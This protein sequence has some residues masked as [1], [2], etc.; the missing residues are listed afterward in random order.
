[1][2]EVFKQKP[3]FDDYDQSKKFLSILG[4]A[5]FP[6][7]A[8]EFNQVQSILQNQIARL[9]D[10]FFKDG[11]KIIDGELAIDTDVYSV[12]LANYNAN[13]LAGL[14]G[15]TLTGSESQ[16]KGKVLATST[17]DKGNVLLIVKFVSSDKETNNSDWTTGEGFGSD[18]PSFYIDG[19]ND[20]IKPASVAQI[21]QGIYYIDQYFVLVEGQTL[22]LDSTSNT[23]SY[24]IGLQVTKSVVTPE[25]DE[26]LLDNAIGSYNYTAP[27][28]HRFKIECTLAKIPLSQSTDTDSF[29][30]LAQ[31]RGGEIVKQTTTTTYNELEKTLARR[32]Y[33]ESGDYTVRPFKLIVREH[34]S[35][36]RGTWKPK[37]KYL[38]GDIVRYGSTENNTATFTAETS[39]T[40][41]TTGYPNPNQQV[42]NDSTDDGT[43]LV[44]RKTID[45]E[46]NNGVY[47]AEGK[48]TSIEILDQGNKYVS[49]PTIEFDSSSGSGASAKAIISDGKLIRVDIVDGGSGYLLNDVTVKVIGG[50]EQ[51]GQICYD[52]GSDGSDQIPSDAIAKAYTDSGDDTKLAIGLESG[53]AYV[54]GFEIEKIGTTWIPIDKARTSASSKDVFLTPSV[55][56]YFKVTNVQ[57]VITDRSIDIYSKLPAKQ[58]NG[59]WK[60]DKSSRIGSCKVRGLEFEGGDQ[61]NNPSTATYKLFVYD[62]AI[63]QGY[64]LTTD[65]TSLA[66]TTNSSSDVAEFV[67][68]IKH[69]LTQLTGTVSK[70]ESSYNLTGTG[71]SFNTEVPANHYIVVNQSSGNKYYYINN[72]SGQNQAVVDDNTGSFDNLIFYQP[73]T[74]IYEASNGSLIY[75]LPN[76]VIKTTNQTNYEIDYSLMQRLVFNG[77]KGELD[78]NGKYAV[79]LT[80]PNTINGEFASVQGNNNYVVFI[81]DSSGSEIISTTFISGTSN[82][83]TFEPDQTKVNDAVTS[84]SFIVLATIRNNSTSGRATKTIVDKTLTNITNTQSTKS[85]S[86]GV[87]DAFK[88]IKVTG[89]YSTDENKVNTHD[90]TDKYQLIS[91]QT[92]Y[93]YGVSS[94]ALKSQYTVPPYDRL[95]V[96]FEYYNHSNGDYFTVDSYPNYESV[97]SYNGISLRDVIDFRPRIVDDTSSIKMIKRGTEIQISYDY[98]LGRK[99]KI[100]L[101]SD[102]NFGVVSGIP[103]IDPQL[104]ETPDMSMNLYELTIPPY[105]FDTKIDV[106]TIDNKRYTMRD[107]GKLE[108]RIN[109]LEQYTALSLL[110]Q[111]TESMQI[112]DQSGLTRFKQGFVV[113]NFRTPSLV[114]DSDS[115]AICSIDIENQLC[116]P[117]YINH[118]IGLYEYLPN[119]TSDSVDNAR[120][121]NNYKMYGKVFT[122]PLDPINPHIAIVEQRLASR[123]VNI[124][125]Y[126][127]ATFIGSLSINPSS[128]DWYD[129]KYLADNVTNVEGN[130]LAT[131]NALEG[132]IWNGWQT[133]WLGAKTTISS[134]SNTVKSNWGRHIQNGNIFQSSGYLTTITTTS[135]QQVGQTRTGIKT[136][137]TATTDYQQVGDRLVSTTL[138]PYLRSRW[139][140]VRAYR[141]KPYTKY[142]PFFDNVNVDYFTVPCSRI[143]VEYKGSNGKTFD[144]TTSAGN[145][146]GSVARKIVATANSF[147]GEQTDRTALDIG[148][149]ITQ[150]ASTG[151]QSSDVIPLTAVVVGASKEPSVLN[152][153][154]IVDVIYVTNIKNQS[155]PCAS[156][157]NGMNDINNLV[158]FT[159]GNTIT[160]SV[161]GVSAVVKYAQG[162]PNP[163]VDSLVTNSN[164]ELYLMFWIPDNS[165][166]DYNN[167]QDITPVFQFTCGDRVFALSDDTKVNNA[168]AEGVYSAVGILNTRQRDINAVRNAKV[169]R[170]NVSKSRVISQTTTDTSYK[171]QPVDPLAQTFSIP[172]EGGCFLSKVDIYFA[173]KPKANPLGNN[174][175]DLLPV[176]L[177]IRTCENGIPTQTILPFAEVTLRPDQVNVSSNTVEYLDD[178]NNVITAYDYSTPTT[179][180]FESPVFVDQTKEYAVVLLSDSNDYNVWVAHVGDTVPGDTSTISKQPYTGTLLKSQNASTWTPEQMEDL[181]FVVYRA[182]FNIGNSTTNSQLIGNIRLA[183]N[184]PP[185]DN[186][187]RNCFEMTANSKSVRVYHDFH[188]LKVGDNVTLS[189][190][191]TADSSINGIPVT[192]LVGTHKVTGVDVNSYTFDAA[193]ESSDNV[194][195]GYGGDDNWYSTPNYNYD[196]IEP[197]VT[198]QSFSDTQVSFSMTGNTASTDRIESTS[199]IAIDVNDNN[200]FTSPMVIRS[201]ANNTSTNS[202]DLII[203]VNMTSN[204]QALSPII[205]TDRL[206]AVLINNI[207]NK[208]LAS[209][210]QFIAETNPT[211]GSV[212]CKYITKPVTLNATSNMIKVMFAGIVPITSDVEVYYKSYLTG[213]SKQYND[214]PWV[215]I[216]NPEMMHSDDWID[217]EF[218]A[219]D[220]PGF[221]VIAIKVVFTGTN[222]SV[223]P[224]IK[225]FRL[226]ACV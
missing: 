15:V 99:D 124:N 129:T 55:G 222:S 202:K 195:G 221:D 57:G 67:C 224:M 34:R 45:P 89:Y 4:R 125:P 54:R 113:D 19:S 149:V 77:V 177:Q 74:I 29:I 64:N 25:Q 70:S 122:L 156:T 23:P 30:E 82:S 175:G 12:R 180:E 163:N 9:G 141:L 21:N 92:D 16:A 79:T 50:H 81:N 27:G 135:S 51:Q 53:K 184:V 110:E 128:D 209:D 173:S 44:W 83:I 78:S 168:N 108:Q 197:S 86:L 36:D 210:P 39:G 165:K 62:I 80:L 170:T 185:P 85:I 144:Y 155:T 172:V 226:I 73:T 72:V 215:K 46:F 11:S 136:T 157:S 40:S 225:D 160:G 171:F 49:E 200:N 123:T 223:V 153:S 22:I 158:T 60:V 207:I 109:T 111:Q 100:V 176:T 119:N 150:S 14:V 203:N 17:D 93:C 20:A 104:P 31:I 132:T 162:N 42:T 106:N 96:E 219:E 169:S 211:G 94:I 37:T 218:D 212:Y 69:S 65:A 115:D 138:I 164:G 28:A 95:D 117:S 139:L 35:N 152:S 220:V 174:T 142:Y 121:S 2:T 145:D 118:N 43:G 66:T 59:S 76:D 91:G 167:K 193:I 10:H 199:Q 13:A 126:A 127:V 194:V 137:V 187:E 88:L 97:P 208:P 52:I 166:I 179:F 206:S 107:I 41:S 101:D 6:L 188:G 120:A 182:N 196:I 63:D 217:Y 204:N 7:Q 105:T 90:I 201:T 112:T 114:N 148:D 5:S 38:A 151:T 214:V 98:Y 75:K 191:D 84:H 3:Y 56:N 205:D 130:Y 147:W 192:G 140:L 32:T 68:D 33:D 18:Y 58:S 190:E 24:R 87:A 189:N 198:Y 181:K 183:A 116:R 103:N 134:T 154:K 143:E 1:M 146:S 213:G 159:S 8:R 47:P 131:K 48:I 216:D 61:I 161:S 186:L 133:S 71:T 26:T 102:G 178:N